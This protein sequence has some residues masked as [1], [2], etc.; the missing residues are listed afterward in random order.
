MPESIACAMGHAHPTRRLIAAGI[1]R[2]TPGRTLTVRVTA[3]GVTG[4]IAKTGGAR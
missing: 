4:T 2:R 1:I 3:A